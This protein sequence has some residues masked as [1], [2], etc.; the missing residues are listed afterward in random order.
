MSP[1]R[2][3]HSCLAFNAVLE[4]FSD[5]VDTLVVT[6]VYV[7]NFPD[8]K[9]LQLYLEVM[10]IRAWYHIYFCIFW[11]V[12]LV[13]YVLIKNLGNLRMHIKM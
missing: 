6:L 11:H 1:G 4:I 13:P 2:G 10:E 8:K 12:K 7:Q 3:N 5:T 9:K